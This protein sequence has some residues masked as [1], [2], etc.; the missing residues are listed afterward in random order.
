MDFQKNDLFKISTMARLTGLSSE[1][2]RFYQRK[3]LIKPS[4]VDENNH[5]RYYSIEDV[6]R[7]LEFRNLREIGLSLEEILNL[8]KQTLNID[9]LIKNLEL[10]LAQMKNS[11]SF[12]YSLKNESFNIEISQPIEMFCL[13]KEYTAANTEEIVGATMQFFRY[14]FATYPNVV[15]QTN[16]C[17][18]EFFEQTPGFEQIE[19]KIYIRLLSGDCAESQKVEMH[20]C[21]HAYHYGLYETL[22][23]TYE[24]IKNYCKEHHYNIVGNFCEKYIQSYL[25]KKDEKQY[26]TE[27]FVQI[28]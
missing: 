22:G 19:F 3:G 14:I 12:L 10:K 24:K 13:M 18:I 27:V 26:I 6:C 5:Y 17:W 7:L 11:L 20:R 1:G 25:T 28:E 8:N 23:E 4:I 16:M 9:N 21:V 15:W 2:I